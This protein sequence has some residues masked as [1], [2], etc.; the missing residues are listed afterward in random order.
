MV[1]F[2]V[3][4]SLNS[5]PVDKLW[6]FIKHMTAYLLDRALYVCIVF[7]EF[8]PL[9]VLYYFFRSLYLLGQHC[10]DSSSLNPTTYM[11]VYR[12][13]KSHRPKL[14]VSC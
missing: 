8:I 12:H 1:V 6:F 13:P 10:S 14:N 3:L 2:R 4:E 5:V 11:R 7:N 9:G